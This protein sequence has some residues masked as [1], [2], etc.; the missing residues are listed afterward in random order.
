MKSENVI[1]RAR[2][3]L[4]KLNLH[5]GV[6]AAGDEDDL[7][8]LGAL[9]SLVVVQYVIA[10]EDEFGVQFR[11]SEINYKNFKSFRAIAEALAAKSFSQLT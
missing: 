5:P 7:F 2:Q 3:I 8:A 9:D 6:D 10:L 11:N 4:K 1:S